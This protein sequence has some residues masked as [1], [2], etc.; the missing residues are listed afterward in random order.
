MINSAIQSLLSEFAQNPW[1]TK[2]FWLENERRIQLM[3]SDI[4]TN[5]PPGE[6]VL[7]VGCFNGYLS[8]LLSKLG[9]RVTAADAA[10]IEG[11]DEM[12]ARRGIEFLSCNLNEPPRSALFPTIPFPPS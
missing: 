7:D 4:Q 10:P 8:F 3:L 9:Y 11:R 1:F 5:V 6:A 12:F 2:T